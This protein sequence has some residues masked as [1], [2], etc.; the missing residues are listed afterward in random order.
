MIRIKKTDTLNPDQ[1]KQTQELPRSPQHD[2][3]MP[4]LISQER[5][6]I[7][8]YYRKSNSMIENYCFEN[9]EENKVDCTHRLDL[10]SPL[11]YAL[12]PEH[13]ANHVVAVQV[14]LLNIYSMELE[15]E[16]FP[17]VNHFKYVPFSNEK[18]LKLKKTAFRKFGMCPM[19]YHLNDECVL[20]NH[21]KYLWC[22]HGYMDHPAYNLPLGYSFITLP[23]VGDPERVKREMKLRNSQGSMK[24]LLNSPDINCETCESFNS[25]CKDKMILNGYIWCIHGLTNK[26]GQP[27]DHK[28]VL[29]WKTEIL[30]A[31]TALNRQPIRETVVPNFT[32]FEQLEPQ[33]YR[34]CKHNFVN[35]RNPKN[36]LIQVCPIGNA[37]CDV[38]CHMGLCLKTVPHIPECTKERCGYKWQKTP[39]AI[40]GSKTKMFLGQQ[41]PTSIGSKTNEENEEDEIYYE[42]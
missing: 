37:P 9:K 28:E 13:V 26:P 32:L 20:L 21:K 7:E 42:Y 27:A 12:V 31:E 6:E 29:S 1:I 15:V 4:N 14:P 24:N 30:K 16:V 19:S 8:P 5:M 10:D 23:I 18:L 17:Q 39:E 34:I 40:N 36:N 3:C 35:G 41:F 33:T 2:E 22:Q 25:T 11:N 38:H